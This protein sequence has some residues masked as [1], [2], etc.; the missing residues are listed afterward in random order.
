MFSVHVIICLL[1]YMILNF[2]NS[3]VVKNLYLYIVISLYN[4][5]VVR[6]WICLFYLLII[7]TTSYTI[8]QIKYVYYRILFGFKFLINKCVNFTNSL[9]ITMWKCLHFVFIYDV[10]GNYFI[11]VIMH[12]FIYSRNLSTTCL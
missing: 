2:K 10:I 9:I 8:R 12:N 11:I 5:I 7:I 4:V 6:L 3:F 1:T